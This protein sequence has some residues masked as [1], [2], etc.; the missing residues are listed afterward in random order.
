MPV[1]CRLLACTVHALHVRATPCMREMEREGAGAGGP[2]VHVGLHLH[3][4]MAHM[5]T[6]LD[7]NIFVAA[8]RP[9]MSALARC[10]ACQL[11]RPGPG[12]GHAICMHA[13]ISL[14]SAVAH[15]L[16]SD[17]VFSVTV[18]AARILS[19]NTFHLLFFWGLKSI[20]RALVLF[21]FNVRRGM[22]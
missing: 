22:S 7:G 13:M 3:W 19:E 4:R 1:P 12:S 8:D 18:S 9:L 17:S 14:A 16:G 5:A 10:S 21:S 15:V 11:P 20:P 2:G 6:C